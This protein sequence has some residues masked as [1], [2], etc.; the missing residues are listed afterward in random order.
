MH[1]LSVRI[2]DVVDELCAIQ[3]ELNAIVMRDAG[4]EGESHVSEATAEI[5]GVSELKLVVDQ[6]RQFLWFYQQV[7]STC[8][9]DEQVWQALQQLVR[10][11]ALAATNTVRALLESLN[12]S[13]EYALVQLAAQN[14]RKPS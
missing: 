8:A 10:Q 5:E 2:K 6:V 11:P 7:T 9:R 12:P 13:D 4:S 1:E 14:T 3:Q